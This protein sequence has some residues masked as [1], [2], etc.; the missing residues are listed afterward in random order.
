M[1]VAPPDFDDLFRK[2]LHALFAWRRDVRQF[3]PDRL[4]EDLLETLVGMAD[5]SPSVGLSQP[6]RFVS[7]EDTKRRALVCES[8][9]RANAAALADYSGDRANLY[10]KL[11]LEGLRECPVHL[12]VFC[13][14]ATTQGEGL[15]RRTMPEMLHYSVVAAISTFWLATRAHGVGVGWV[16]ILEPEVVSNAL[17]VP[18]EWRLI[19]YLC[20]GYPKEQT[21]EPELS[22]AGWEARQPQALILR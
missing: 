16:S 6:W 17:D 5:L 21:L 19:A 22:A 3:K 15:G 8:F 18:N 14:E 20:V 10:A 13:D 9:E 2:K 7:V 1:S 12:A 4:P 11:K